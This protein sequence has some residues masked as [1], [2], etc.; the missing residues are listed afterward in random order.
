MEVYKKGKIKTVLILGH[1]KSPKMHLLFHILVHHSPRG[2]GNIISI[3][4]QTTKIPQEIQFLHRLL[5]KD[6]NISHYKQVSI[7]LYFYYL[8]FL[9]KKSS[10]FPISLL[11]QSRISKP[12]KP[13][14]HTNSTTQHIKTY[15]KETKF[16][17]SNFSLLQ[18]RI[19]KPQIPK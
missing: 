4:I 3:A 8:K 11:L 2:W 14:Q 6:F 15:V 19:S 9:K 12:H 1:G 17:S 7:I 10:F 13:K 5:F 18:S 16:L